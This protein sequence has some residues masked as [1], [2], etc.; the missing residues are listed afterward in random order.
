MPAI[1]QI[2]RRIGTPGVPTTLAVGELAY[3]DPGGAAGDELFIG[4]NPPGV[5]TLIS[6]DRQVEI[7]GDQTI[8]G[9]KTIDVAN[10][11]LLGGGNNNILA[12]DGAGNLQWTASPTG[13]ILAVETDDTLDG[14]GVTGDPLSVVKLGTARNI[15]LQATGGTTITVTAASFDGSAAAIMTGFEVTGL[16]GGTF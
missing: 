15:T 3:N 4:T 14:R 12:T 10:F 11:K 13:G 1:I 9:E 8:N 2:K 16:D 7:D 5:K 6:A